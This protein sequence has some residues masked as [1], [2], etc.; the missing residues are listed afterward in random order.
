[1]PRPLSWLPRLHEIRRSVAN[2]VRSHYDRHDLERLF[3]LQPRAA[4][5]LIALLPTVQVGTSRLAEREALA[6]FLDRIQDA[7]DVPVLLDQV[8]QEKIQVS[9][10]RVRTLIRRDLDP[11]DLTSLPEN[12]GFSRGRLEVSF[13]S[14]EEL[15]EALL[16]VARILETD[17][18]HFAQE[19]E[20]AGPEPEPENAGEM[21]QL[22][23]ELKQMEAER[24]I[25]RSL[26]GDGAL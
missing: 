14:L 10:K 26:A 12:V 3:E 24:G 15:A 5:K 7:E 25:R 13:R 22:F 21:R 2:S 1:M 18:D 23:A 8:R 16:F 17:T 20:P 11:I 9:R 19:Y 6:A 4:Q